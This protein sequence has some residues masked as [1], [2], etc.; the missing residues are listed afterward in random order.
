M[1]Q[2]DWHPKT[3]TD[4]TTL[5]YP[6]ISTPPL[7]L[8]QHLLYP[9]PSS[10][11]ALPPFLPHPFPRF[12]YTLSP[13]APIRWCMEALESHCVKMVIEI[14][15]CIQSTG[16]EHLFWYRDTKLNFESSREDAIN[17]SHYCGRR[18]EM[19]YPVLSA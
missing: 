16:V 13:T 19:R 15:V 18:D 10:L 6:P 2:I 14:T 7:P 17:R 8:S 3:T 9:I 5:L 1:S 11:P 4:Y 12:H